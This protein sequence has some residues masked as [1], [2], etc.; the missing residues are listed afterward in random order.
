MTPG[1]AADRSSPDGSR[2]CLTCGLCCKGL[3]HDWAR[4]EDRE[5]QTARRLGLSTS[6]RNGC[7]VFALPCPRHSETGCTVYQERPSPCSGYRCKLLR[8]YLAGEITW[9]EGVR[10][11]QQAK[12]LVAAIRRRID[13]PDAGAS[14]WQQLGALPDPDAA[15]P[16]LRLDVASLM[17]LCQGHFRNSAEPRSVL[18][19]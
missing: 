8:R 4:L 1:E 11:V 16:E 12:Q 18:R 15:E 13:A 17:A 9:D 7:A 3:L 5:V 2:L 19:P 10:R 6:R 14:V